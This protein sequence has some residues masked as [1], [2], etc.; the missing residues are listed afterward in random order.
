MRRL[1]F[2]AV[3]YF[4]QSHTG[5]IM[6]KLAD[7]AAQDPPRENPSPQALP[8]QATWLILDLGH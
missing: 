3:K 5:E 2:L 7:I 1:G 4:A 8:P 6:V